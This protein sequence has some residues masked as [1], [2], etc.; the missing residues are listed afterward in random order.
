[1]LDKSRRISVSGGLL[2]HDE[3]GQAG[4]VGAETFTTQTAVEAVCMQNFSPGVA[5]LEGRTYPL[6]SPIARPLRWLL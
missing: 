5:P 3:L 1:M 6:S 4:G 2:D